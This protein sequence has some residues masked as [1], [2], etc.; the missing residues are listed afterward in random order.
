MLLELRAAGY[1]VYDMHHVRYGIPDII[2]C[3]DTHCEWVEIKATPRKKLTPAEGRFAEH[4]PGGAPI[5]A[6]V[7]LRV[8]SECL[9]GDV[10]HSCRCDCGPQLH[11]AMELINQEGKGAIVYMNQEGRGIGLLNK[12]KAYKLQEEGLDTYEANEKLGFKPDERDY[13]IGA[14]M[15]RAIGIRNMKLMS[16]NP[17]KRTGLIG[18]GLQITENIPLEIESNIH[19]ERYL[20]T[21]RDKMGHNIKLDH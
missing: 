11:K 15:L 17:K 14:Q 16:N 8:H 2:M 13:G 1:T 12:L 21:K 10:F 5:D 4:C 7:L 20:Q 18:Y 9:T 3:R 19:N 6:P